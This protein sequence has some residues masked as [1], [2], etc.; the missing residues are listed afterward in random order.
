MNSTYLAVDFGASNGRVIAGYIVSNPSGKELVTEEVY[1]FPNQPVKIGDYL[2]WDFPAL[3]SEM[4]KGLSIAAARYDNIVSIGID[5]WGVDFGMIDRLGNLVGN[6]VCYRDPHSEQAL[7]EFKKEFDISKHYSEA[8]IQILSI[9]TLFRLMWMVEAKDPKLEICR[10]L[11]FMPDLFGYFL[12]GKTGNEYTIA[13]TSELLLAETHE[14]N[15]RLIEKIG[16]NPQ[17]FGNILM[18]GSIRGNLLKDFCEETGLKDNVKVVSVGSHDTA[19]AVFAMADDFDTD[20][21]AFLSSGTWSLLGVVL[22]KPIL[23]EEARLADYTN[24]GGVGGKI[25]FLTNITGLWILQQLVRQWQKEGMTLDWDTLINEAEQAADTAILDV[26]DKIFQNPEGMEGSIREYCRQHD[27]ICP[28]TKGEFVRC[29]CRSLAFRYKKALEKLNSL[30]P[31]PVNKL[32][33]FG[34]GAK[35]RLLNRFTA[36]I[37]G[38][39]VIV[40]ESEAT[41]IGNLLIQAIANGDI[42]D[43]NEITRRNI[44]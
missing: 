35:N 4:K 20:K 18:P 23:S 9:N 32:V 13:S 37:T 21:A 42:R 43:R 39:E 12:T 27:L 22:D 31:E 19:S 2:Y 25:R 11:L 24:E 34:G 33:V 1:R 44:G 38:L 5:T 7:E 6:P 15:T 17:I 14:W 30:L 10:H 41:A 40:K 36:E 29:V 8:G 28:S 3:F 26:D 16:V